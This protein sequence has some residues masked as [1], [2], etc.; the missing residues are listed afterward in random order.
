[1]IY[2]FDSNSLIQLGRFYP[3]RFPSLWN[4]V[5]ELVSA[6]NMVSVREVY[7]ELVTYA[8]TDVI[9]EWADQNK[10]IFAPPDPVE[11]TF[12]AE[13]LAIPHFQAMISRQS[14]LEGKPVADPF[15]V[16]AAKHYPGTV[17]TEERL[18]PNAAKIPNI[19]QRFRVPYLNLEAFM[20]SQGW[21]Y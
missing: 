6:G 11:T 14:L 15:V 3:S 8:E 16:A 10:Q 2:V 17:V 18:K 1:M 13:I 21:R 20:D 7:R 5:D 19:C 4:A 9:M 12:V